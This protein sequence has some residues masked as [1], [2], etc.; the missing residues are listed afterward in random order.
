MCKTWKSVKGST[1]RIS[2]L[3][4]GYRSGSVIGPVGFFFV[5]GLPDT[6][7]DA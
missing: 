3:Q 2:K 6:M 7:Q 1:I 5:L 4:N